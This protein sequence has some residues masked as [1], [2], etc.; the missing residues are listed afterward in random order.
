[1]ERKIRF[2]L[3]AFEAIFHG[4]HKRVTLSS[5]IGNCFKYFD[6]HSIKVLDSEPIILIHGNGITLR[7]VEEGKGY[8]VEINGNV[9]TVGIDYIPTRE[10]VQ[11]IGKIRNI[12]FPY[13]EYVKTKQK[14]R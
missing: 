11:I 8:A 6:D 10:Q 1:M 4:R 7:K 13:A 14:K 5:E 12:T 9:K 2:G 3:P